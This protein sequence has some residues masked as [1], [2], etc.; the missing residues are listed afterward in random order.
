MVKKCKKENCNIQPN[1]NLVNEK[2]GIFCSQHKTENMVDIIRKKCLELNCNTRPN[3]N[4]VNEK[5]GIFC[6]KHK[7]ENM[8]DV[9]HKTC[10][11]E[12]C[13]PSLASS[14]SL[15]SHLKNDFKNFLVIF[16]EF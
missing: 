5:I 3:F 15:R 1:F 13:N 4:L 10:K 11:E 9:M 6:S 12:H 2:F 14:C 16:N 8:I 7:K